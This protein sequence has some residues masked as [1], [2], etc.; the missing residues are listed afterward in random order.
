MNFN[1]VLIAH[2]SGFGRPRLTCKR[3]RISSR[4]TRNFL[5]HGAVLTV[6]HVTTPRTL[7]RNCA[8]EKTC[9]RKGIPL[10]R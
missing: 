3:P 8:V 1:F 6:K 5:G 7:G 2:L 9:R 4:A 10:S